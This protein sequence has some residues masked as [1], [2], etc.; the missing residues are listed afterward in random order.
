MSVK[1]ECDGGCGATCASETEFVR[2]GDIKP[3]DYCQDCV[4]GIEAH[5]AA[6]DKLHDD[7]AARFQKGFAKLQTAWLAEHPGGR[8]PDGA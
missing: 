5:N 2:L 4:A 8:L 7:V 1:I 3:G 6:V